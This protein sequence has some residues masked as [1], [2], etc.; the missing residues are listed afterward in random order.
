M[1]QQLPSCAIIEYV[2]VVFSPSLLQRLRH[3]VWVRVCHCKLCFMSEEDGL[4]AVNLSGLHLDEFTEA[5]P[6]YQITSF[7]QIQVHTSGSRR[8]CQ[9]ILFNRTLKHTR[10][11]PE[12]REGQ[13][14]MIVYE[15]RLDRYALSFVS[16]QPPMGKL[17]SFI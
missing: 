13:P 12:A 8:C 11:W 7:S 17:F 6:D 5:T 14:G 4:N 2:L 1:R 9:E 16:G 15:V 10:Q 3:R